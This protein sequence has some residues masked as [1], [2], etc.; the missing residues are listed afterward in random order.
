[1]MRCEDV[2][3]LR[4][5]YLALELDVEREHGVRD[6]LTTCRSCRDLYLV[7][8]PSLL[9]SMMS[10]PP[11]SS[12]E[13]QFVASVL[14]GVHQARIDSRVRAR[15]KRGYLA[16]AAALVLAVSGTL[17]YRLS[18]HTA[19]VAV[20]PAPTETP[21]AVGSLDV[22][23]AFVAV[24]GEGVRLYQMATTPESGQP[25]QVAFIVDPRLEL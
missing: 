8:E 18:S 24:E 5:E 1:M 7:A 2:Q 12:D 14:A 4:Q 16:L 11:V 6:H 20:A 21:D 17:A 19:T 9:F 22:E 23:P 15:Q 25:V 13:G 10:A 3:G